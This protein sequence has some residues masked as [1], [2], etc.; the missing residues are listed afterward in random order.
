MNTEVFVINECLKLYIR[1]SKKFINRFK[2]IKV[3]EDYILNFCVLQVFMKCRTESEG[4][5]NRCI[6]SSVTLHQI[7]RKISFFEI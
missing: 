3:I 6:R 7:N 1:R 5:L 4:N 2:N